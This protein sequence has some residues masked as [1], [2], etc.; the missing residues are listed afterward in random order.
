V[1]DFKPR[2]AAALII[3]VCGMSV[4]PQ[5]APGADGDFF[6]DSI[7]ADLHCDA[8]F[9]LSRKDRKVK[10]GDLMCGPDRLA[11]G[12]VDAQVFV[13]WVPPDSADPKAVAADQVRAFRNVLL[14]RKGRLEQARTAEDVRRISSRGKIAAMLGLEG[15]TPL[16]GEPDA[17]AEFARQGI[18]YV[19]LTWNETNDFGQGNSARKPAGITARGRRLVELANSLRVIPDVSHAS[20]STFWGV[21]TTSTRPVIASHS[22]LA[23]VFRHARNIDD[24]QLWAIAES[25]G[26]VGLN[27]FSRFISDTEPVASMADLLRHANH[28]KAVVGASHLAIGSD[29]D[30]ARYFV[31]GL[32]DSSRMGNLAAALL[33]DGWTKADVQAVLG[34]N[35]LRVLDATASGEPSPSVTH[36][37]AQVISVTTDHQGGPVWAVADSDTT[38]A[39]IPEGPGDHS[40]TVSA[41]GPGVDRVSVCG[42]S[43]GIAAVGYE[44]SVQALCEGQPVGQSGMIAVGDAVRPFRLDLPELKDC[45][46][47]S[48]RL[49][50]PIP[51]PDR[52]PARLSEVVLERRVR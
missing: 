21:M 38:T 24:A 29:F 35:F 33:E 10:P 9:Q 14:S 47:P 22:N 27:L 3:A 12:N 5:V 45:R 44:L 2:L 4:V 42:A 39:W 16:G 1:I 15:C 11:A 6:R 43:P 23:S 8:L 18:V 25:G 32:E 20:P 50:L 36:M 51:K 49:G 46:S 30:G 48:V 41:E 13:I 40:V 31:A 7:V 34:G 17:L 52:I 37:P 19:S 26:L 28:V